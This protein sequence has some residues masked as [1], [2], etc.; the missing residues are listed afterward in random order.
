LLFE[1]VRFRDPKD[2]RQR[3]PTGDGRYAWNLEGIEPVLYRLP[4][5]LAAGKDEVVWV[6][7]G[8]KDADRLAASGLVATCNPMGAGKWRDHYA[9]TLEGRRAIV[10]PDNDDT[11][12]DHARA[13]AASLCGR[14]ASV[15]VVDLP[16]LPEKGDVSDFLDAGGTVEQLRELA[17][18]APEWFPGEAEPEDFARF[19]RFVAGDAT[20][21][22]AIDAPEWP[23]PPGRPL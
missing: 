23:A 17:D 4:E 7:E 2:F 19:A 16:D 6:C 5:L 13:V 21:E 15:K 1:V 22:S 3:R 10:L 14:A 20:E 8:E 9:A 18:V 11:G 12:R